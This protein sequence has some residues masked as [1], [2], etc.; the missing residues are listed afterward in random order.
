MR[1]WKPW[2]FVTRSTVIPPDSRLV[3]IPAEDAAVYRAPEDS[4]LGALVEPRC[5]DISLGDR[6]LRTPTV[7]PPENE[8]APGRVLRTQQRLNLAELEIQ[9]A[10]GDDLLIGAFLP[11]FMQCVHRPQH[12]LCF[13]PLPHGHVSFRPTGNGEVRVWFFRSEFPYNILTV[14]CLFLMTDARS[15]RVVFNEEKSAPTR[16]RGPLESSSKHSVFES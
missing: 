16:S 3:V 14:L 9:T 10:A 5:G 2:R 8:G 6:L 12:C 13:L 4:P 11:I 1:P 7:L 15:G